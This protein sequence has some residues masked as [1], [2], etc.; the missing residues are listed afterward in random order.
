ARNSLPSSLPMDQ[1][2]LSHN[3]AAVLF[4]SGRLSV[5]DTIPVFS[6]IS[7]L[8]SRTRDVRFIQVLS[9]FV[10][11]LQCL[12]Q[13]LPEPKVSTI[14]GEILSSRTARQE[15]FLESSFLGKN[16]DIPYILSPHWRH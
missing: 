15:L 3:E 16:I 7:Q 14:L 10:Q 2:M 1:L 8:A 5:N 4:L 6:E 9:W 13:G 11:R 12:Q